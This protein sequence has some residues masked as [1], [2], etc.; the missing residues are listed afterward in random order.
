MW[1][2]NVDAGAAERT[3]QSVNSTARNTFES[4]PQQRNLWSYSS[5]RK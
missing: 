1:N 5:K 4:Q 3:G 2:I